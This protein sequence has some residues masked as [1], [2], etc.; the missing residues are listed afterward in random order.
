MRN[1]RLDALEILRDV[2]LTIGAVAGGMAFGCV[3]LAHG[4]PWLGAL[5]CVAVGA[6]GGMAVAMMGSLAALIAVVLARDWLRKHAW[7]NSS[8]VWI[9]AE[10]TV[11]WVG[12]WIPKRHREYV[13]GDIVEIDIP[14]MR[15][16]GLAERRIRRRVV[17]QVLCVATERF[18]L[19]KW[20]LIAAALAKADRI[21]TSL[22]SGS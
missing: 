13:V 12:W 22:I 9:P 5:L 19:W 17:F 14:A 3:A 20:P 15:E 10:R 4:G 11:E 6:M 16:A 2:G 1:E 21:L 7:S 8:S 18:K